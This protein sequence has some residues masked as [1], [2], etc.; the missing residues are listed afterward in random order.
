MIFILAVFLSGCGSFDYTT[1]HGINV[2]LGDY[3]RP[4]QRTIETWTE[5]TM[6]FWHGK[7][8]WTKCIDIKGTTA[9]FS[10]S[11]IITT[12]DSRKGW[13]TCD[14]D[15]KL[16]TIG[17]GSEDKY[18]VPA[19]RAG[20]IHELSHLIAYQCANISDEDLSHQ[21]FRYVDGPF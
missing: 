4:S 19:V 14:L 16:L 13:A 3:N 17:L 5:G 20:F 7:M 6:T 1:C 10:D 15:R 9:V 8:E 11:F 18:Y 21:L 2:I 12:I